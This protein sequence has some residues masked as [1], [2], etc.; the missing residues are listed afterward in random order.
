MLFLCPPDDETKSRT[1][2]IITIPLALYRRYTAAHS[3]WSKVQQRLDSFPRA[4]K[5]R[6][7]S[8][9]KPRVAIPDLGT[10]PQPTAE[11]PV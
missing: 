5:E 7:P 3:E 6:K 1:I 4:L 8:V 11:T 2:K 10:S 9:R